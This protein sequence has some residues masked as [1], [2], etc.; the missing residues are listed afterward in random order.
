[1]RGSITMRSFPVRGPEQRLD[2]ASFVPPGGCG[3][4]RQ[5]GEVE[6]CRIGR[7]ASFLGLGRD[8]FSLQAEAAPHSRHGHAAGLIE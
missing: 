5:F 3:E 8:F 7:K 1:M 4:A 6:P 2:E